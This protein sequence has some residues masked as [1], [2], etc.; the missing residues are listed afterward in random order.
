MIIKHGAVPL[1]AFAGSAPRRQAG[2]SDAGGLTQ[3]GAHLVTL[4]PGQHSSTR[5]WH[6]SEDEFLYMLDGTGTVVEDS[7]E[8][9][10][11]PGDAACWPAGVD[12]AH[13]VVNRSTAPLTYLMVGTRVANDIVHYPDVGRRLFHRP[14]GWQLIADDGTVIDSGTV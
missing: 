12:N 14:D 11:T 10:I 8:V 5:H 13:H 9:T 2:L 4:Q 6:T 7:G 1:R 3:F